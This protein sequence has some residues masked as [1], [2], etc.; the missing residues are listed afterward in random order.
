MD[1]DESRM[2]PAPEAL[3]T[4]LE[5]DGDYTLTRMC[6]R[7]GLGPA[8]HSHPHKQV[9]YVLSGRGVFLLDGRPIPVEPGSH[10]AIPSG[11][12]HTF[13]CVYEEISWLEFFTPG[14]EDLRP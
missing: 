8:P 11:A 3:R 9:I 13:R 6:C 5:Y 14:R 10:V 12:P 7:P 2:G 1:M 4:V